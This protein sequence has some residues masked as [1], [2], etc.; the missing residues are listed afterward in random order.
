MG[1]FREYAD[2][3]VE[4]EEGASGATEVC[5]VLSFDSLCEMNAGERGG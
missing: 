1:T 5:H 2:P 4:L 3:R